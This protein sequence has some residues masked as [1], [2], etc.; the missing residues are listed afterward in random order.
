MK[1]K[2][3]KWLALV[4]VMI[5]VLTGCGA[6]KGA[7]YE[8]ASYKEESAEAP[9]E[10]EPMEEVAV[11]EDTADV[12]ADS[13]SGVEADK[14]DNP[15][16]K[17]IKRYYL[18]LETREYDD[19]VAYIQD[20]ADAAGGYIESSNLSGTSIEG[21]GSRNAYFILRIPVSDASTFISGLEE[22]AHVTHKSEE[23]EDVTLAYVD[24]ESRIEALRIEQE[25]LMEMLKE[26]QELDTILGIQSR[27]TEVRYELESYE[28]QIRSYDNLIEYTTVSVDIYEV[29]RETSIDE[30]S[31]AD[32]LKDN[33]ADGFYDF[34]LGMQNFILW[35]AGAIPTLLM[36]AVIV[37]VAIAVIKKVSKH[38]KGKKDMKEILKSTDLADVSWNE[39]EDTGKKEE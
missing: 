30:G 32:R 31:F 9:M 25:T 22:N 37:V 14:L 38:R 36:L 10:M 4:M 26:A 17:L 24:T 13:G 8:S 15:N 5:F 23:V 1:K 29:K 16:R 2:N 21:Y 33:F 39:S 18:S 28:S 35:F 12:T 11:E 27:L 7:A 6:L 3:F 20:A 34:G 19:L